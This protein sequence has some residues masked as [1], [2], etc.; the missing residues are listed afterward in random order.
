MMKFDSQ[1]LGIPRVQLDP[2]VEENKPW[3]LA[4]SKKMNDDFEIMSDSD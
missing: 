3:R 4:K 2:E 1:K